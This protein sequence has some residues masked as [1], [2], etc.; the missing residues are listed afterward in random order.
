MFQKYIDHSNCVIATGGGIITHPP[1]FDL[2]LKQPVVIWLKASFQTVQNRI[3]GDVNNRRPLADERL[4]ERFEFRQKIYENCAKL[5]IDVDD[6][7]PQEVAESIINR[8]R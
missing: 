1:S 8:Y 5:V 3:H 6:L 7:T 2:M 4:I